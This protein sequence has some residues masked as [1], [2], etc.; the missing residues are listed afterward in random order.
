MR[1]STVPSK[2]PVQMAHVCGSS[3]APHPGT[4]SGPPALSTLSAPPGGPAPLEIEA[5]KLSM[6][7]RVVETASSSAR[8][9]LRP[10]LR[11]S[12]RIWLFPNGA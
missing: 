12:R 11:R 6:R 3:P 9:A 5:P 4:G 1:T 10:V 2:S 7:R 8:Q